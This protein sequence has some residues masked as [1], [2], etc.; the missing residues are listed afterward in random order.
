MTKVVER[1]GKKKAMIIDG[2]I[3]MVP[4]K[5]QT[6]LT[7]KPSPEKEFVVSNLDKKSDE[8]KPNAASVQAKLS[9]KER[10]KKMRMEDRK[11]IDRLIEAFPAA[12]AIRHRKPLKLGVRD[13]LVPWAEKNDISTSKLSRAIRHYVSSK[14]YLKGTL[15]NTHR[16]DL[17]GNLAEE[18]TDENRKYAEGK[19]KE[20]AKIRERMKNQSETTGSS[21]AEKSECS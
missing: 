10:R 5:S 14:T 2:K 15:E 19:L 13:D 18:V 3:V 21:T 17:E 12:F 6:K 1:T 4:H 9:K 7:S 16:V 8:I 20:I 11:L